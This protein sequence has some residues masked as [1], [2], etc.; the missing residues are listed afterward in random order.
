M[1]GLNAYA[2][3]SLALRNYTDGILAVECFPGKHGCNG[4]PPDGGWCQCAASD[5]YMYIGRFGGPQ[6]ETKYLIPHTTFTTTYSY[7]IYTGFHTLGNGNVWKVL[8]D[9]YS[10]PYTDT[11]VEVCHASGT[12]SD[13]ITCSFTSNPH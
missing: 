3:G 10:D 6:D 2:A 5:T 13:T 11:N 8:Q 7:G 1:A 9:P 12:P 4:I